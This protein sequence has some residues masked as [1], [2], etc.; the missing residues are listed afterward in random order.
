MTPLVLQL[1]SRIDDLG[2]QVDRQRRYL[3]RREDRIAEQ[4][5]ENELLHKEIDRLR[6]QLAH[7]RSDCIYCG[8]EALACVAC[9]ERLTNDPEYVLDSYVGEEAI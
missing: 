3:R 7:R 9:S 5:S 4:D 1:R 2:R 6:W 8:G